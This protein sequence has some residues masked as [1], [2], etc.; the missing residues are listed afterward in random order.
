MLKKIFFKLKSDGFI[1]LIKA[2][3]SRYL[4]RRLDY[5]KKCKNIFKTGRGLEIGGPSDIFSHRGLI[6][7]YSTAGKIDNVNFSNNTIWEG[8]ISV[9]EN[10]IFN[11]KKLPGKQYVGEASNLNFIES[12]SYEYVL[13]S[14]CIE[15]LANP[16]QG[17]SEWLRVLKD[18]GLLVLILPHKD[19]TF[20]HNRPVS[21]LHHLIQDYDN[22]TDESDMTHLKEILE[23]HDL[24]RDPGAGDFSSF[25]KRSKQNFKNRSLHQHVFDTRLAV[26]VVNY[27][28]LHILTVE[29]ILPFHIAIIARKTSQDQTLNNKKY[30]G[31]DIEPCWIS[32]FPSD[33]N[34]Y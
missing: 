3:Y 4:P 18:G 28:G 29:I 17:M 24:T 9:G 11:K 22:Q 19:G 5:F 2:I 33:K 12:S 1:S 13:S 6:P 7:I 26:E 16:I 15:H 32:P 10:F 8:R 30:R 21:T 14:H 34:I 31:G 27:M 20:D 25:R 23:L